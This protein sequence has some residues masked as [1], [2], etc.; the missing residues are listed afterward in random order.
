MA[1]TIGANLGGLS[2]GA[3]ISGSGITVGAQIQSVLGVSAPLIGSPNSSSVP[4]LNEYVSKYFNNPVLNFFTSQLYSYFQPDINSYTLFFLV[5]PVLSGYENLSAGSF[6]DKIEELNGRF[7]V[8]ISDTAYNFAIGQSQSTNLRYI[9]RLLTFAAIDFTPPSS[10]VN[11][12]NFSTRVGNAPYATEINSSETL[13]VT[14]IDNSTLDIYSYHLIWV[15]YIRDILDGLIKPSDEY[16]KSSQTDGYNKGTIV[17]YMGSAYIVRYN[18][19]LNNISHVCKCI[20][21]FPQNIPS[22]ELI[23]TRGQPEISTLPITYSVCGYREAT[24]ISGRNS[25]IFDELSTILSGF[26]DE[27]T[28]DDLISRYSSPDD[29]EYY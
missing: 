11:I 8:D 5:P 16:L 29:G 24:S 15:E 10:V 7:P 26:G 22:K 12:S 20:G 27:R 6:H 9:S 3:N 21:V 4:T 2:I 19:D 28:G 23:G 14:M 18:P 13:S 25:F 17:D 1:I